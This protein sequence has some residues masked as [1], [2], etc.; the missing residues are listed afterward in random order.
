MLRLR[1]LM[2]SS[3]KTPLVYCL[4]DPHIAAMSLS[5]IDPI[6]I[7]SS[8]E[9]YPCRSKVF[10][11]SFIRFLGILKP[12]YLTIDM[13]LNQ[14]LGDGETIAPRKSLKLSDEL[15]AKVMDRRKSWLCNVIVNKVSVVGERAAPRCSKWTVD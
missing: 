8:R 10:F 13:I 1:R 11:L 3:T 9:R 14:L 12:L 2:A 4:T 7:E 5:T 15:I 6:Q